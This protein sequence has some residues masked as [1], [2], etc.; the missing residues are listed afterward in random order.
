MQ[1]KEDEKGQGS[2]EYIL[3]FGALIVIAIAALI[4]YRS[5]FTSTNISSAEDINTVR[6]NTSATDGSSA[7]DNGNPPSIP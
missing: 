1:L 6:N 2:A 3:L 5:Y 4:I 7:P